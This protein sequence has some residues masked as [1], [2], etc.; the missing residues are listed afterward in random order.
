MEPVPYIPRDRT[1]GCCLLGHE[2]NKLKTQST[3]HKGFG[4]V[5]CAWY[6]V[7]E[8][9]FRFKLQNRARIPKARLV[10]N[11]EKQSNIPLE[12]TYIVMLAAAVQFWR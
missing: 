4:L 7:G 12:K 10:K 5:K 8:R 6:N 11:Q 9:P 1:E 3:T 2:S